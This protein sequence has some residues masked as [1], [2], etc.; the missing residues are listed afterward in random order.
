MIGHATVQDRMRRCS[1]QPVRVP[2]PSR[3]DR[4]RS[5]SPLCSIR[6][7]PESSP[8]G[9]TTTG[10]ATASGLPS[11]HSV[12]PCHH[13]SSSTGHRG[14]ASYHHKHQRPVNRPRSSHFT[15]TDWTHRSSVRSHQWPSQLPKLHH[16]YSNV[17]TTKCITLCTCVIIFS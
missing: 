5:S 13:T 12:P 14:C 2:Q 17:P 4:T 1:L 11:T 16:P 9:K 3:C 15:N 7:T 6:S 8:S 10:H